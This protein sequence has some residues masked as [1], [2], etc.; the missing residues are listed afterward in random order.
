[1]IFGRRL[2]FEGACIVTVTNNLLG[3]T[4]VKTLSDLHVITHEFDQAFQIILDDQS[5][6][7]VE[8][9]IRLI[10]KVR[11]VAYG[12]WNGKPVVAKL[13][14]SKSNAKRHRQKDKIGV[15]TLQHCHVPTP[16]LYFDGSNVDKKI[17]ILLF[18]RVFGAI[19]LGELFKN[20]KD[21][22]DI[23]DELKL[24]VKELATQHVFGIMQNDL[25]LDNYLVTEKMVYTLDG[26][27]IEI[28]NE[29]LPKKESMRNLALFFSQLGVGKEDA[30][31]KL[32]Y[33][34]V[35][36]RG[37]LLKPN[38]VNELFLLINQ[39]N[40]RRWRRFEKKIF[41]NST[42]FFSIKK[43]WCQGMTR[44]NHLRKDLHF[45]LENPDFFFN[46]NAIFL[47]R[48]RS[49]TV[50]RVQLDECDV[51]IKRYNVKSIWHFLRRFF[52]NTRAKESWH[53]SNKLNLFDIATA[54]PIAYLEKRF[55]FFASTSYFISEYVS[56]EHLGD[57]LS[58][59]KN[60]LDEVNQ[61]IK[62]TSEL[63]KN[64]AKLEITHGDLK[65]TNILIDAMLR[66]ILIDLDGACEHFS[67]SSL[68]RAWYAEINRFL[69]NFQSQPEWREKFG[70]EL[71]VI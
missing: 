7:Y 42:D 4:Q 8:K 39:W 6:L 18:S 20:K 30:I 34:Y 69:E 43:W 56:N 16:E 52:R 44:R 12:K 15:T 47:K 60:E 55:L 22:Q 2:R 31:E 36:L 61:L 64:L 24:V 13:F 19:N 65:I 50:I 63:L 66:P 26:S 25:H 40:N 68:H 57:Y 45:F 23:F 17:Q 54:K 59:H 48:G 32:F 1:M 37:W 5:V 3:N 49:A 51:V 33:H 21:I 35:K 58:H 62:R 38:D 70:K 9:I 71:Y 53:L 46:D 67:P 29:R 28:V 27:Q 11:L 10:P 14:F 41:R